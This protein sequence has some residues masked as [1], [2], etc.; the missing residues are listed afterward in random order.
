MD[1]PLPR[2]PL[3]DDRWATVE[4]LF[5]AA[6]AL[7]FAERAAFLD[8]SC[9][10]DAE[11][12]AEVVS[13][14]QHDTSDEPPGMDAIRA[15]AANLLHEEPQLGT[16]LGP[17]RIE[18]E[19]GRGGMAVVYLASRA[20]GAYQKQVAIKLIKRG[21]DTRA[22]VERLRRERRIL[23][24]LDHPYM[25]RLLDGG[26]SPDGLPYIVMDYVDGVPIDAYCER[27][28]LS[29]EQRCELVGKVCEA[30]AY[31]HRNLVIHRDL[32]P[33]NILIASDGTPKL[34]DFGI[35]TAL[36][37]S[38][39]DPDNP[40][41]RGQARPFTPEYASPEQ[42]TGGQVGTGADVYSLGV[43]LYELLTTRRACQVPK[44]STTD[45]ELAV[46]TVEPDRASVA[47]ERNGKDRKWVQAI[48]GDIDNIL[49]MALR[50][51]PERRY[52][53]V[54][55]FQADLWC[56]AHDM[57]VAAR[58]ESTA[59]RLGKFLRRHRVGVLAT[60]MVFLA[61]VA[62]LASTLWQARRANAQRTL[63][64]ARR[65]DAE[66]ARTQAREEANQSALAR[67]RAEDEHAE[68]EKQR[69]LAEVQR[70][71]AEAQRLL[72][73]QRFGQV[74]E[75]ARKFL[76]DFHDSIATLPGSTAARKMVVETALGY[77]DSLLKEAAGN[78]ALLE[79]IALGYDRLG[80]VQ[81]SAFNASFGDLPGSLASYRKAEAIRAGIQDS[82]PSFIAD[83]IRGISQLAGILMV[84][85][86]LGAANAALDS[87]MQVAG[88]QQ[89]ATYEVDE[90][91][92]TLWTVRGD[93]AVR[94]RNPRSAIEAYSRVQEIWTRLS[95]THH[96]PTAEKSGLS[97]ANAKLG[98]AYG[99]A[100][101]PREAI[102]HLR[103]A[104]AL[105]TELSNASPNSVP[106][107]RRL[108]VG[109][110]LI[111]N[112]FRSET[113]KSLAKPGEAQAAVEMAVTVAKRMVEAD[114][115]NTTSMRDLMLAQSG[116]GDWHFFR[117][118]FAAAL[119]MYRVAT[120]G[121]ERLMAVGPSAERLES[122][123]QGH[124]RAGAALAE[125]GR[126]DEALQELDMASSLLER[127]RKDYPQFTKVAT[128][129]ADINVARATAFDKKGD[130][131]HAAEARQ[132]AIKFC[133]QE[134]R[135]NPNNHVLLDMMPTLHWKLA[136]D[137]AGMERWPTAAAAAKLAL[138][139]FGTIEARRKL[140]AGE[141]K[142]R[143]E[144]STGLAEWVKK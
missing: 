134:I 79:E 54:A 97:I 49:S 15:S 24:A 67:Q 111:S 80:A 9:G 16:T 77:Y 87:A 112:A 106:R 94:T 109:Y 38:A 58:Q 30:V 47:A 23:A 64:E 73:E 135:V 45:V 125:S 90:A 119:G 42:I 51:E 59:Y 74:R 128:W 114:P 62:G 115:N 140:S 118:E 122:V 70:N 139:E 92:A 25:A 20:D 34:L 142:D 72:A 66:R 75:L 56:F 33:S 141:A 85:G 95:Q 7:P 76:F 117:D 121:A 3:P 100:G 143:D 53:S 55:Q 91:L 2:T 5:D 120:A 40:A 8:K 116:L 43:V 131:E 31:A 41:T 126:N 22:V 124:H 123:L 82:S 86:E 1:T 35:A 102:D 110:N 133:E 11:L 84:Q 89:Q 50:K 6:S 78:R 103:K 104:I 69:L 93:V 96:D 26:T 99:R 48:S 17:Y 130:W 57:P 144:A 27:N 108:F 138:D 44:M 127:A 46:K 136:K 132:A 19:V 129:G 14:L 39:T 63:A 98:D 13:L 101:Q 10:N 88:S 28:G 29:V 105:D 81:G 18:R 21:M 4:A 37:D 71:T 60:A 68:A 12:R 36:D 113:G 65:I 137:Y 32:K 83:R 52:L 107:L 61:L